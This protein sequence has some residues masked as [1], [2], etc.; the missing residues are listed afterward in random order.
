MPIKKSKYAFLE[1]DSYVD[2]SRLKCVQI[3]KFSTWTFKGII[4]QDDIELII[5]TIKE[6]PNE[7]R[8]N[9]SRFGIR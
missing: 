3:Q 9:L 2:C 8:E 6:S 1:H 4:E 5:D 7:K